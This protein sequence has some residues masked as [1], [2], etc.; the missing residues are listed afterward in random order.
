VSIPKSNIWQDFRQE[1][2]DA[3]PVGCRFRYTEPVPLRKWRTAGY[4]TVSSA[5]TSGFSLI[6]A[7]AEIGSALL[8]DVEHLLDHA[9]EHQV[10]IYRTINLAN[11][12]SPAWLVVT[13]YYW[14]FFL[15]MSLTRLLGKTVWYLDQEAVEGFSK[16]A[17]TPPT[18]KVG[19]G[20]FSLSCGSPVNSTERGIIILKSKESR[21]HEHLWK[22]F[23]SMCENKLSAYPAGTLDSLEERL[24]T[25]IQR[26]VAKLGRDW[27]SC[28]RNLVNYRPGFAYDA[29]RR[30]RVLDNFGYLKDSNHCPFHKL[31]DRLENNLASVHSPHS[32]VSQPRIVSRL[33]VDF[34]F[35][36]NSYVYEL[37][38]DVIERNALDTRWRN[39][40]DTFLKGEG[41]FRDGKFWPC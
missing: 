37:H 39:N 15:A 41:L 21:L 26:S 5:N 6:A 9:A 20:S 2:L 11:W 30:T 7:N 3:I 22:L 28:L 23:F 35:I 19:T 38:R 10:S 36:L 25:C 33:L 40:R 27:P 8:C 16:S 1:T 17:P 29:V 24:F 18:K 12:T 4:Y 32:M 31:I 13:F 14:S 34:T